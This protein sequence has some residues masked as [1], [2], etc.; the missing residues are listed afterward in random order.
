MHCHEFV[1]LGHGHS[2]YARWYLSLGPL[3]CL[4]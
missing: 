2:I 1:G 4:S 3:P